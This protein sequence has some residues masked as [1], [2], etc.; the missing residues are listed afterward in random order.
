VSDSHIKVTD[1]R[2]FTQEGELRDEFRFL[3]GTK[4]S[5]VIAAGEG[6]EA[7][8]GPR[9]APSPSQPKPPPPAAVPSLQ[10]PGSVG[11]PTFFDLVAV[12][13]EPATLYLGEATLPDGRRV[14]DPELARLHIDLLELLS[15]KTRGNL[16]QQEQAF[17]E[18]LLYRLRLCYV[19]NV[20]NGQKR[21]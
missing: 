13:A 5:E 10:Q 19:Q 17:V 1:K 20:R 8:T 16:S 6:V 15:Q 12:L 9:Q 2:M 4:A 18:D 3:D 11:S 14:E 7:S 21:G